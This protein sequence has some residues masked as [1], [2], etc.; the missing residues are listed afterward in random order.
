MASPFDFD[1]EESNRKFRFKHDLQQAGFSTRTI[2][3]LVYG[4]RV[5]DI[6]ELQSAPWGDRNLPDTLCW[7]LS[8]APSMGP[9]GIAEVEAFRRGEDPRSAKRSGPANVTVRLTEDQLAK[10][11]AYRDAQSD[12]PTRAE[13]LRRKAFPEEPPT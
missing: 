13:A 5:K 8:V 9:K 12:K 4:S 3:A 6:E 1:L 11:D 7:E 10:L 2:N